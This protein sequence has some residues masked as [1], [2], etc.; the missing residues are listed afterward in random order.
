MPETPGILHFWCFFSLGL[1]YGR[2][3]RVLR[4]KILGTQRTLA[5]GLIVLSLGYLALAC[6]PAV[7]IYYALALIAVGNGLFKANHLIYSLVL[8]ERRIHALIMLTHFII[9][10]S[11]LAQF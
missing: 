3:W 5:L 2:F 11:I 1:Q 10:Q 9:W 7:N 4:S 6:V 8:F